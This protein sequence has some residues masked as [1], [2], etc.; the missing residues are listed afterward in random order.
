MN[1]K[2]KIV[3][4]ILMGVSTSVSFAENARSPHE[5][6]VGFLTNYYQYRETV[7]G[8]N[9]MSL[10]GYMIGGVFNYLYTAN[11]QYV[12]GTDLDLLGGSSSY[13]S[14]WV[15]GLV[16]NSKQLKGEARL[17]LGKKFMT[18]GGIMLMPY[19]GFG[20]RYKSDY[21]GDKI[22]STGRHGW[23]RHSTYYYLPVGLKIANRLSGDWTME[24]FGEFDIFLGGSQR[25]KTAWTRGTV[26]HKQKRGYGVRG[27]LEAVKSLGNNKSVSFGPYINYWN[28]KDSNR[29][30]AVLY[31]GKVGP[32][33]EPHN[34]T[35]E[36]GLGIK[37]RF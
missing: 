6:S 32:S 10:K 24:S 4:F 31:N 9:F 37:Y 30:P 22:F 5:F 15:A 26:V 11:N 2:K 13:N 27:A 29:M 35:V 3:P 23:V 7:R 34:K 17:I 16:E 33:L 18:Y 36:V 25:S 20:I 19:T 21:T 28:I 8:M 12:V 14:K 1:F